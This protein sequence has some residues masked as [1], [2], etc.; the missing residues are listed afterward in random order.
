[1]LPNSLGRVQHS[2]ND[3]RLQRAVPFKVI[4]ENCVVEAQGNTST[5]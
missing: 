5:K 2:K 3:S 4:L 1:M